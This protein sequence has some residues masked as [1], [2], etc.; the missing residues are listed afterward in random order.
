M[1]IFKNNFLERKKQT[2]KGKGKMT[3]K[4]HLDQYLSFFVPRLRHVLVQAQAAHLAQAC[5]NV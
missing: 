3:L 1:N 5:F 4:S 2:K